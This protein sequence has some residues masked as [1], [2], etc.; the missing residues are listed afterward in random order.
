MPCSTTSRSQSKSSQAGW[1][2]VT[3]S[4]T[5]SS[6]VLSQYCSTPVRWASMVMISVSDLLSPSGA[7]EG[8]LNMTHGLRLMM[9]QCSQ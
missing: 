3:N 1:S 4:R 5:H 7:M 6:S 2:V 9:S 8:W